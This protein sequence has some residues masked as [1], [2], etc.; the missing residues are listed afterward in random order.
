LAKCDLLKLISTAIVC[1]DQHSAIKS[2]LGLTLE[3]ALVPVSRKTTPMLS[4]S[5]DVIADQ[6]CSFITGQNTMNYCMCRPQL[7]TH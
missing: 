6:L 3:T 1:T 5:K 2:N 4:E 7:W